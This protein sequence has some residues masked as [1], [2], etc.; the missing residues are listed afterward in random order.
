MERRRGAGLT[1]LVSATPTP[2]ATA[3]SATPAASSTLNC[4][5]TPRLT[6][7]PYWVDEKLNRSDV[8]TDPATGAAKAGAPLALSLYVANV[9]GSCGPISDATVD[10]WHCDAACLYSDEAANNTVGQKFLRGYQATNANG[11]AQ[12]TTIYPGW[13]AG[14]AVHIHFRVR[15]TINGKS[16]NFTSQLFFDETLTDT[17]FASAPYSS[18]G[19]QATRNNNDTIYKSQMQMTLTPS[20]SG[21]AAAFVVGLAV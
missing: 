11:L 6:E 13:Y 18:R 5:A 10:I 7:G 4:V 17:V 3:S 19:A 15:A 8:R 21:Y 1:A 14:R 20:G 2:D 16:Y 9:N 12:F